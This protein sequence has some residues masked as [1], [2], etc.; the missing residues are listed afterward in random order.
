[1]GGP[2]EAAPCAGPKF[3]IP[4]LVESPCPA[5]ARS[6]LSITGPSQKVPPDYLTLACMVGK[7][8]RQTQIWR[9]RVLL[10]FSATVQRG[11]ISGTHCKDGRLRLFEGFAH[12]VSAAITTTTLTSHPPNLLLSFE[13]LSAHLLASAYLLIAVAKDRF[14]VFRKGCACVCCHTI[15]I[16]CDPFSPCR[17]PVLQSLSVRIA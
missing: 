2:E 11:Y 16:C 17:R 1:M 8:K 9:L 4:P 7:K 12:H 14:G 10:V 3:Q 13:E 5:L 6:K 15:S